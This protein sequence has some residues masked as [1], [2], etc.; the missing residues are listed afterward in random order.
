MS[1]VCNIV[2]NTAKD[3]FGKEEMEGRRWTAMTH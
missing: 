3:G 2:A 1:K